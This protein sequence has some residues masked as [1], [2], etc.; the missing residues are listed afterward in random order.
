MTHVLEARRSKSNKFQRSK[1]SSLIF[2]TTDA[3]STSSD[4]DDS[5][6]LKGHGLLP[7]LVVAQSNKHK[8]KYDRTHHQQQGSERDRILVNQIVHRS[9]V[10]FIPVPKSSTSLAT[11]LDERLPVYPY[12]YSRNFAE[13]S[14]LPRRHRHLPRHAERLVNRFIDSLEYAHHHPVSLS[15][16]L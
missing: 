6:P 3:T 12:L 2:K 15:Q 8:N 9:P 10:R 14:S 5:D 11:I 4:D 7:V 13:D 16:P 1:P